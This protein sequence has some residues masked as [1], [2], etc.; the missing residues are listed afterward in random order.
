MTK[1]LLLFFC[2]TQL[3]FSQSHLTLEKAIEYG[4][5]N[6]KDIIISKNDNKIIKNSNHIGAAG[7]LPNISITSGYNGSIN[8]S[9]LEFNSFLDFGGDMDSEIDASQAKSSSLTSSIGLNYRLFNGFSGIYTLNKFKHQ[10]SLSD[11]S[12]RYQIENK[13]LEIVEQYYD[14]LNKQNIYNTFKTSY[15]ISKDRY[16]QASDKYNYGVISKLDLLNVEVDLNQDKIKMEEAQILV[17]SAKLNMSLLL[18]VPDSI[19]HLKH[20][21]TF[22]QNFNLEEL[23]KKTE[24]NNASI[25]MAQYNYLVSE[26]ELKITKSNFSPKVDLFS[27]YSYNNRQSETSFIS[28]QKDYGL[29]AGFNIEIPI[30]SANMKRKTFQNAKINLESKQLSVKQIKETIKTALITAY[31]NYTEGLKNLELLKENL[32]TIEKTANMSTELYNLGQISNLEYRE[33][34]I[35]FDQAEI[36]YSSKLSRTKIQEYIIYQLSGQLQSE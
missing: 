4:I 7:M 28:K 35:L 17:K 29:I 8:N 33:A 15:G 20:E 25:V 1:Y 26:Y 3:V 36:D 34:Q 16:E 9:E 18:G 19:I 31:H 13:I 27:S 30:F 10:N 5:T 6:S 2:F 24:D 32:K 22:N 11:E 12:L 23:I 14:L 21:F